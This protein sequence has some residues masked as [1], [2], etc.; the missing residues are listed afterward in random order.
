M[1]ATT[2][3]TVYDKEA[4]KTAN[5]SKNKFYNRLHEFIKLAQL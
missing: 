2:L 3:E 1:D 5:D 4:K